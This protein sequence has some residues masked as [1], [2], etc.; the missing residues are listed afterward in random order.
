VKSA[1]LKIG[2]WEKAPRFLRVFTIK[3]VLISAQSVLK[4]ATDGTRKKAVFHYASSSLVCQTLR[5]FG[6]VVTMRVIGPEQFGLFAQATLLMSLAG[7]CREA[8]QSGALIAYQGT[9]LRYVYFN[10]QMNFLLGLVTTALVFASSLAPQLLLDDLRRYVWVVALIPLFESLTLTNTLM[11]Q[12]RF[13]FKIL[14]VAEIVSLV[15]WLATTLL[16][17]GHTPGFLVLLFAQ[18]AENLCR[19]LLLFAVAR[20]QFVGFSWGKDLTY[21]YFSRFAK[22]TIVWVVLQSLLMRLDLL[23]LTMFSSTRELGSYERLAQ[24]TRIPVSLTVNLCD[25]VVVNAYSQD[26]NDQSALRKL[27]GRS[28]LIIAGAVVLATIAVS[29]GLLIFLRPLIGPGWAAI[30]MRLWWFSVPATLMS[31]LYANLTLFFSGL[32]MQ[33][34]LL[35]NAALHLAIVLVLGSFLAGPFGAVGLLVANSVSIGLV[36]CYQLI[37][38]R[39]RLMATR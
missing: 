24:F 4:R 13:R 2:F 21:Y 6:V 9:D 28:M 26:Q 5:F 18:L 38:A 27:F 12:K 19:C 15:A 35:R 3:D 33:T 14:G 8:G 34:Q 11:L 31:P 39:A 25:K 16:T 10:F 17:I 30:I 7:L 1:D 29:I 32:G 23:L 36:L 37:T 22:P 20:F